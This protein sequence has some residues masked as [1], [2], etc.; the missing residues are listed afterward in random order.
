MHDPLVMSYL[1]SLTYRL[2]SSSQ[3]S[4]KQLSLVIINSPAINAFAV[5]GGIIGVNAGLFIHASS[6]GELA[7]V[8]AHELAHLSQ[9][10][11]ARSVEEAKKNQW[12]QGAALLASVLL[13]AASDSESGY[14]ALATTQAAA[15]QSQ[16]RFSRQN[17]READRLA[18]NTMAEA[19]LD[20]RSVGFFFEK[21]QKAY[22]YSGEKPPEYL[23]T[24]PVTESRV[25]DAKGR[26]AQYPSKYYPENTDFYL[27]KARME[28]LYAADTKEAIKRDKGLLEN[29]LTTQQIMIRYRLINLLIRAQLY[30]EAEQH[31]KVLTEK[32]PDKLLLHLT[33]GQIKLARKDYKSALNIMKELYAIQPDNFSLNLIYLQA[34]LESE[35]TKTA[36][37]LLEKL[38]IQHPESP[39]LWSLLSQAYG[40]TGDIIGVH[41][42][43]AEQLFL[44][45]KPD[46]AIEQLEYALTLI[47]NDFPL[48][49]KIEHRILS[50]EKSR[51][52]LRL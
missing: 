10:H 4:N 38:K 52:E 49:S 50:I 39:E 20:P 23:L 48:V 29:S 26:A 21:L 13:I 7:G 46:E 35:E 45:G 36:L 42:A 3:L 1:Q 47:D 11:F 8:I 25:A 37:E 30:Q 18:M 16:L 51:G 33:L 28:A 14:A 15:V 19:E 31:L 40:K 12:L 2:A 9:R 44:N 32:I 41:L 27:T 24:H 34:L 17:E 43:L 22:Q 6:E 5:P